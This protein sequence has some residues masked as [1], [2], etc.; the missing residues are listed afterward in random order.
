MPK[1][2]EVIFPRIKNA[3]DGIPGTD[4]GLN[5]ARLRSNVAK[6]IFCRDAKNNLTIPQRLPRRRIRRRRL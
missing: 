3:K 5:T 2:Y 4:A 1:D 6:V